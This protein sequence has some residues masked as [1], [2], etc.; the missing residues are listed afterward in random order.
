M[1]WCCGVKDRWSSSGI[2]LEFG[3]WDSFDSCLLV[4]DCCSWDL[5]CLAWNG[6]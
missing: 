4:S 2:G 6:V 5:L 3:I 1:V